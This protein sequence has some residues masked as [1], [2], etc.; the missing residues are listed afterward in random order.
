[1]EVPW[2]LL[3]VYGNDGVVAVA[4]CCWS[5]ESRRRAVAATSAEL[6]APGKGAGNCAESLP[7]GRYEDEDTLNVGP[8]AC[9][10]CSCTD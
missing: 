1:M 10:C 3:E 2:G 6:V 7:G 5:E 4:K 9:R 8:D